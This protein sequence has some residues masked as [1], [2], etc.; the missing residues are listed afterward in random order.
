MLA[1]SCASF[2]YFSVPSLQQGVRSNH[3]VMRKDEGR[4]MYD[5]P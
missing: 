2:G 1:I 3:V 5:E 4:Y